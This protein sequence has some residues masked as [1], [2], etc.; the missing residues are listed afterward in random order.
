MAEGNKYAQATDYGLA[1][2]DWLRATQEA[3]RLRKEAQ[4]HDADAR[5]ARAILAEL[6]ERVGD[7]RFLEVREGYRTYIVRV[8]R[9]DTALAFDPTIVTLH[10][11]ESPWAID[12]EPA[13][14]AE[15]PLSDRWEERGEDRYVA[16]SDF[17]ALVRKNGAGWYWNAGPVCDYL[18][19]ER[20][21]A[22]TREE[23]QRAAEAAITRM[24]VL[25]QPA[26][27]EAV[28]EIGAGDEEEG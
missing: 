16:V 10:E 9:V 20:G 28:A 17:N 22:L 13:K 15:P 4:T 3:E 2:L 21:E 11:A 19:S 18:P 1:A 8:R 26:V 23:A 12:R 5:A 6:V 25:T 24:K 7:E 14:D 27:A